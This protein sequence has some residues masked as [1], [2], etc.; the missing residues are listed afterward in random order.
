MVSLYDRWEAV[1]A[2]EDTRPALV[3]VATGQEWTFAELWEISQRLGPPPTAIANVR[4]RDEHFIF[5]TLRAWKHHRPLLPLDGTEP[6]SWPTPDWCAERKVAHLKQTSGSTGQARMVAFTALQLMADADNI[7]ATMGLR[8]DWPNVGVISLAHSYGFSNLVLPLLLHGIPLR[9]GTDPL[10]ASIT[11]ALAGVEH[12]TLPAVPAMWKAWRDTNVL[13]SN[14]K[15]AISAGAPLSVQLETSIYQQTGLKVH[16][17]YG[18]SECGGIAYDR[19]QTPRTEE[20]LAGTAMSGVRLKVRD[21]GRLEVSSQAVGIGYWPDAHEDL[22]EGSYITS[23]LVR[24]GAGGEIYL[25]GR[26]TEIINVAGRK[27]NPLE[28]EALLNRHSA[29]KCCLV[30]GQPSADPSRCEDIVAVVALQDGTTLADLK[31]SLPDLPQW[32]RPRHWHAQ[33]DLAP[34]HRGKI[35]RTA[36]KAKF[37]NI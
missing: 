36:W 37:S 6:T 7:V 23:D 26:A 3:N 14:I 35:S 27:V 19:S 28:I 1:A 2:K 4:G 9:L 34:D 33:P 21:A 15:L 17:F 25:E 5:E 18:S 10:P 13:S 32:Q 8:P 24:L 30:F 16:N 11:K 22:G 20:N 29:V 31:N 12:A